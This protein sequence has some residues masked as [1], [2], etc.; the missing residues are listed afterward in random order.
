[1]SM[2]PAA[3]MPKLTRRSRILIAISLVVVLLLLIGPRLVD[4][5]VDWLWFG[6]LGYRSVFTTQIVT[7][8]LIF[9]VVGLLI[10]VVVFAA[11]ALAYR[12]RPV[13]VPTAGPNDPIARYRTAVMSRLRLIGLGVPAFIGLLSGFV[14]QSYWEQVQLFLH[15]GDFGIADPQFGIDLGFYAF[16]LPFYR[17]V[18]SYL[19]VATFLAFIA[20]L[21]GHY[22]FGGIRLSGRTGALSRAARIQL[23]TLI[24][25]LMLLK[26]VAYWF[27]RYELL[28]H[29]RGGKPFTGAGYTDINAV[30]PA[31]L[32][33][34]AIAV[35]C[36][37]AVFSAI[38]LRDLRIPAIGVVLLLLS[39]LIV[40]AG[41]PL[42]VEQISVRPNAAQ[43][44]SEYIG[45]SIA[46]TRQAYGLTE[47]EVT[48]R[49]YP[50]NAPA[51]AQQVAADRATTSNIRVLDPNI[52]APAFTQFQQG[53]N[54]YFFSDQLN[55]DRYPDADGNLRDYVVAAR[56]LNPD[57]LIDNQR[58]WIN[59][60]TVFTHGNGFIAS[61]ANTVRGVAN[62]PNQNG[63]YPE[64]LAS[65]VGANG[66]V[67]SP[68]PA[69]LDQ[70]RIYF[71]PV[72]ASTS[73]DYAIVGKNGADREY[74]YETNT[75]TRNYTY[76]GA[77]G[78][79]LGNWFN[80]SVFAA[81]FAERNFLFSNVINNNSKILFKRDPSE[82]VKAVAPWL[83]TDTATYPAIVNKRMV[84]IVDGYT[85][86]DNYPYS[87]LTS[88]SSLTT[89]SNEVA[90]NRLQPDKQV[91]YIRNSVKATVDAYD[92][93]VTL[94]AQDEADPVLQAWMKVFPG[95]IKP[96]S[97]ISPEL[98]EHLRYPE[99]L[100]K[101]QRALLAK[102]HVDDPVTFFSTS[103]FW[104]VPLD[105]NPTASS[106]QPPYYIVAKNLAE[107]NSSTSFQLTSAMNRF[108]RDF[109]AAY[110]SASSDP[111]TYGKITVLTI[112]G[113]V[114][115]PKL[116]FNAISTDTAVSQD[117]GV[118]G[119]DNQNRIRWGN[120]LTLPLGQGGLLYVAPVYASPGASDAASSYPRL[121]RVAMM[122]NDKI[123][124]GPT[125]RDALTDLFGPG[126]D[127]T[128]TG[129]APT[130][131]GVGAQ[132][133]SRPQTGQPPAAAPPNQQGQT[134]QNRPEVPVA[135]PPTGPTQ[136]S[137]AKS[138]A[139]E[140]V[141]TALDALQEAQR[142]GDFAR[143]GEALQRLDDAVSEYKSAP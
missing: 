25:V 141:N 95:T 53:K 100:F 90:L 72:I 37:A 85:T 126:A 18:L 124:Y 96:K 8:L 57:R 17:L 97:E 101:V 52:V 143:Y 26:A 120:L 98:Q 49:D 67:I 61:P 39:S 43:K 5:Y 30:L 21:L 51:T 88:L 54:F 142:S 81:K 129:P 75:D 111:D 118:I 84:W 29:T 46:A 22:L 137:A 31:K 62:D 99:D 65:V 38:V 134:P 105:P 2:R 70:P 125:V 108:R 139:L 110:I 91:S 63:G 35:I 23:I 40:G 93:T 48:Y 82:R 68:G 42:V 94:Y 27:D 58:D 112:P 64:F 34:M 19:F 76:T 114:N 131:D 71:G 122:Y 6:E 140:Q 73:A 32:I 130:G 113:Q 78:V 1:M 12:T 132:P 119:R 83:T 55:M 15:G 14:A 56:E 74:D 66:E 107:N 4:A 133:Q 10:G 3:R 102:Y 7:R 138:A 136:L 41:W 36:A 77:G 11:L 60:H 69:P 135:V 50:G 86:L 87:E 79:P 127:A 89:D 106:Y 24:G 16:D 45:R 121:I 117:L 20:N 116:A 103:D 115:G 47:N 128:A 33:L 92:G 59:R 104:D 28:S 109:L 44:E 13:F 80:R 123:G 9:L